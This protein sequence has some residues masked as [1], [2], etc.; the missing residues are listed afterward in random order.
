[1]SD[2]YELL[3]KVIASDLL[4]IPDAPIMKL[5][6]GKDI[7]FPPSIIHFASPSVRNAMGEMGF[8]QL[9]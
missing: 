7:G 2:P 5:T 6:V 4:D 1:M 9:L 3:K 8:T